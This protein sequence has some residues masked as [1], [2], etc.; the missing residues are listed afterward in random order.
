PQIIL[1]THSPIIAGDFLPRDII[2]L[3]KEIDEYNDEKIIIKPSIGFGTSISD[4]YL[5]G[6]HLT[7]IFGEHSKKHIDHIMNHTK[8]GTLTEFDKKL[9]SQIS[10]KYIRDY[11]LSS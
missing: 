6:M 11:L 2:S 9:I 4:L 8:N 5:D 7:A 3:Y 1:T 10:D